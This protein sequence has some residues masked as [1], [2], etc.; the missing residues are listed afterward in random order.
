M[1]D[2]G[3]EIA[4]AMSAADLIGFARSA[5][6]SE[7]VDAMWRHLQSVTAA[8]AEVPMD[9]PINAHPRKNRYTN[10]IPSQ[11]NTTA[12]TRLRMSVITDW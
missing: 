7:R 1:S 5:D 12:N 3:E 11:S 10:V 8:S 9:S 2:D 4:T 6:F